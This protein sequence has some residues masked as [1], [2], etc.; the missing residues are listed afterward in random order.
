MNDTP[1]TDVVWL[2][3]AKIN[4]KYAPRVLRDHARKL[5]RERHEAR[6]VAYSLH[7]QL[8][9]LHEEYGFNE[10]KELPWFE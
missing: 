4:A 8:L 5:E 3:V 6:K 2:E 9:E 10:P 1:E 7:M